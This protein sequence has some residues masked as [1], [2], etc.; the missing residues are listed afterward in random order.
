MIYYKIRNKSKPELYRLSGT[1][2]KWNKTGKVWETLGRLRS[3]ITN[4]VSAQSRG[5]LLND[6]SDWEIV[7]YEVTE[8]SVKDVH[9]V[10]SPAAL[11]KL[12]KGK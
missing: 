5:F 11:M 4:C 10:I 9:D 7:E 2:P 1:Y 6:F 3:M 12:L 8:I